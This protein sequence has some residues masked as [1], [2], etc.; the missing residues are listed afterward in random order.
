MTKKI[1]IGTDLR[2]ANRSHAESVRAQLKRHKILAVNLIG[3]PGCGKT[4]ILEVTVPALTG[5]R[6]AVIEGDIATRRDADRIAALG[7][8][9]VQINTGGT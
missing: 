3:S 8:S 4:T 2:S 1:D 5:L 7:I 6:T 9:S